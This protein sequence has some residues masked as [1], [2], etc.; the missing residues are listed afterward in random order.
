M[1]DFDKHMKETYTETLW[2]KITLSIEK[3]RDID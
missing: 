1:Q 2:K 3:N